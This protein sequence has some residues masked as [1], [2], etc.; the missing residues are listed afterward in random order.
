MQLLVRDYS[1]SAK[2]ILNSRLS[3]K[4]LFKLIGLSLILTQHAYLQPSFNMRI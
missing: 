3:S 2:G 4:L 1:R